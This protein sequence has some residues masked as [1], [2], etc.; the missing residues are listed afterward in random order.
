M[1]FAFA[2][3]LEPLFS[4]CREV[5]GLH[6]LTA[7]WQRFAHRVGRGADNYAIGRL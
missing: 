1:A 3:A 6:Y 5:S 2:L 4:R 7:D